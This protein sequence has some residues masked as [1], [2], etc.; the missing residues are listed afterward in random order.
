MERYPAAMDRQRRVVVIGGGA[1]GLMSAGQAAAGGTPVLLLE[2]TGRLATKLRITGKGRCNLTNTAG[3]DEFLMHFA[4]PD[5][6]VDHLFLR[7]AF[8]RFSV[9]RLT[10]SLPSSSRT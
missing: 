8:A 6:G 2:R 4:F 10:P 3:C 5:E 1:A 9:T 7:N